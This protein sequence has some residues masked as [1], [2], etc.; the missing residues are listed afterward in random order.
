MDR[1]LSIEVKHVARTFQLRTEVVEAITDLSFVVEK[2][3]FISVVGPS[4]C[5]KSTLLKMVADILPPTSGQII[6]EGGTPGE[7]A[8]AGCLA[9]SFKTRSYCPGAAP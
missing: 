5:G 1:N 9:W 7:R 2:G 6:V 4:G 3:E 8:A